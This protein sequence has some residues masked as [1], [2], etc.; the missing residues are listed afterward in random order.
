MYTLRTL[1][2]NTAPLQKHGCTRT[3][4]TPKGK[5]MRKCSVRIK[6]LGIVPAISPKDTEKEK[7]EFEARVIRKKEK[8]EEDEFNKWLKKTEKAIEKEK[9]R[10]TFNPGEG[11]YKVIEGE[12]GS[13]VGANTYPI[14]IK[15]YNPRYDEFNPDTDKDLSLRES[16]NSEVWVHC[17]CNY[18]KYNQEVILAKQGSSSVLTTNGQN[19]VMRN[20]DAHPQLCKHL[21]RVLPVLRKA[22]KRIVTAQTGHIHNLSGMWF[23]KNLNPTMITGTVSENKGG[24]ILNNFE[25]WIQD[26]QHFC[27][28]NPNNTNTTDI[29]LNNPQDTIK[30]IEDY[31]KHYITPDVF[32]IPNTS[33]SIKNSTLDLVKTILPSVSS[34][35]PL[36]ADIDINTQDTLDTVALSGW[37]YLNT[38]TGRKFNSNDTV[39]RFPY[40]LMLESYTF[41]INILGKLGCYGT[42][43]SVI[44]NKELVH[45]FIIITEDVIPMDIFDITYYGMDIKFKDTSYL[46]AL[47]N[48]QDPNFIVCLS[49]TTGD[50]NHALFVD[51]LLN[52]NGKSSTF[53]DNALLTIVNKF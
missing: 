23:D 12:V 43:V 8:L 38:L 51:S 28:L 52:K 1:E 48:S 20:P 37:S 7:A 36:F 17:A 47:L 25:D 32:S 16:L 31:I 27:I 30:S 11:G 22:T 40:I 2:N 49:K 33:L 44:I 24:E 41:K 53:K 19:P 18:F 35:I 3:G 9:N 42:V 46:N 6:K 10:R 15:I 13:A 21:Y 34:A 5:P 39:S 29:N 14:K 4:T 26:T 50:T 45:K